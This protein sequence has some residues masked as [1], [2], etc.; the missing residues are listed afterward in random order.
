[1]AGLDQTGDS[2]S[3]TASNRSWGTRL[4]ACTSKEKV[5]VGGPCSKEVDI[6][7]AMECF[8]LEGFRLEQ[9]VDGRGRRKAAEDFPPALDEVG[10]SVAQIHG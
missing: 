6:N 10:R 4:G 9:I 7:V 2:Q 8:V 1:M 5:A 3:T